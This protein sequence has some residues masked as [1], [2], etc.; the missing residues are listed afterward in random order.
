MI[1]LLFFALWFFLPAGAANAVPVFAAKVR[2]LRDL[3]YP[4]DF[5]RRFRGERIFGEHKTWRGFLSGILIATLIVLVQ[6]LLHRNSAQLRS[7]I[8][9]VN[10][11]DWRL[12]CLGPLM[13]GGALVGDA[14]ESFFKRQVGIKPG[15]SW[16]PFD[17]T[18][19]ILGGLLASSILVRLS[20]VQYLSIF[21]TWFVIHLVA[22]YIGYRVGLRDKPI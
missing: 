22:T 18:D 1:E 3:N 21:A 5:N 7:F 17:Q 6:I 13:G 16:F 14:I 12:L 8:D 10:Y 2:G 15:Q 9:A 4:M 11:C 20:T 19:Y